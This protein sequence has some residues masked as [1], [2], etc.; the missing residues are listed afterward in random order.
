[1]TKLDKAKQ[2]MAQNRKA[3]ECWN[4]F[5]E[6]HGLPLAPFNNL[7]REPARDAGKQ[8]AEDNPEVP[9][10]ERWLH[11]PEMKS[12]LARADE[13]MRDNPPRESDLTELDRCTTPVGGN[14]FA[15][16][17]FPAEEA[18]HLKDESDLK[19]LIK[20]LDHLMDRIELSLRWTKWIG[21]AWLVGIAV[22]LMKAFL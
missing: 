18:A 11:T 5:V 8:W 10:K 12:K 6:Q 16:L 20:R 19:I 13:W 14:V 7:G 21:I 22:L 15:D 1:M 4:R 3:F 17:G 2:W 9:D